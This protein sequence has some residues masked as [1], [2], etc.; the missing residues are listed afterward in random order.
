MASG[1]GDVLIDSGVRPVID[2]L[3]SESCVRFP[4]NIHFYDNLQA[5]YRMVDNKLMVAKRVR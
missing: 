3:F 1:F 4:N 5:R 2:P